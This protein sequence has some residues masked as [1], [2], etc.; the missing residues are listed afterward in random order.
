LTFHKKIRIF[1]LSL[2]CIHEIKFKD[3]KE[4]ERSK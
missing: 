1:K 4:R 3:K 2:I